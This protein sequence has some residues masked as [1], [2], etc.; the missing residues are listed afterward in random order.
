[1]APA[2]S[3][4]VVIDDG[5]IREHAWLSPSEVLR[6]RDAQEIELAP[7][8]WVTLHELVRAASVH[9]ALDDARAREPEHFVTR[10]AVDDGGPMALWHGDA[11]YEDGDPANPG[12]RHRLRMRDERWIYERSD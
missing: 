3:S 11:G 1:M 5:E 6:R 10:I 4:E 8:T 12:P 9:E 2:P 7:P